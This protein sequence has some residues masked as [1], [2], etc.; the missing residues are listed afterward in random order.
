MAAEMYFPEPF[1]GTWL[2]WSEAPETV[3]L[4]GVSVV[5]ASETPSWEEDLGC[6]RPDGH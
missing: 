2:P 3:T 1:K 4:Q 5:L 6:N